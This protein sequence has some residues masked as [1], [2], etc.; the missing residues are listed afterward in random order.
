MWALAVTPAGN[1]TVVTTCAAQINCMCT[2]TLEAGGFPQPAPTAVCAQ[3][4]FAFY[5]MNFVLG[6]A[7]HRPPCRPGANNADHTDG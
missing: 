4:I 7:D 5:V 1:C 2:R 6:G 3:L